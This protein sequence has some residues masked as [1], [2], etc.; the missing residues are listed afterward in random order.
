[1][2]SKLKIRARCQA[3]RPVRSKGVN[4]PLPLGEG[5]RGAG[6]AATGEGV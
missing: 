6:G 2:D 5:V 3:L 4:S 1:M